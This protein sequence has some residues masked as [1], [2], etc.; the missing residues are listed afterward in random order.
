MKILFISPNELW[1]GA[2]IANITI[3]KNLLSKGHEVIYC[4]EYFPQD[5]Y[6]GLTIEHIPFHSQREYL[7]KRFITA[8]VNY[9]K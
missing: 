9:L 8:L 5:S 7:K 3:A 4:D 1:G 2:A 6:E